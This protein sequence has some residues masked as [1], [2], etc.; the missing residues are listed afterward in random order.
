MKPPSL[1]SIPPLMS[2]VSMPPYTHAPLA[3]TS[4]GGRDVSGS[5]PVTSA[6]MFISAGTWDDPPTMTSLVTSR[7]PTTPAFGRLT[8]DRC[9]TF[10][11]DSLISSTM[12]EIAASNSLLE[13]STELP[14]TFI[15]TLFPS[16]NDIFASSAAASIS[17]SSWGSPPPASALPAS[18][19]SRTR[20]TTFLSK[21][22]PP[23]EIAPVLITSRQPDQLSTKE[24]SLVPAPTSSTAMTW[25]SSSS[26]S[27]P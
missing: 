25:C 3:T 1:S 20:P 4:I 13:I 6:A 15:S 10:T 22:L 21:S 19:F 12:S 8:P 11:I 27:F 26:Q 17:E 16:D 18:S 24:M 2:P 7:A 14:S 5:F 23:R 9:A